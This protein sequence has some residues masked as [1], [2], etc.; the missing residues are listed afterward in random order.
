MH[1]SLEG[2]VAVVT[3]ASSGFGRGIAVAL[4]RSGAK[5]CVVDVTENVAPGNFDERPD[6]AT[7]RLIAEEGGTALYC[8]CDVSDRGQVKAAIA[9][10][11]AQLGG[12]DI[13]VNNAG[14]WRGMKPFHQ[15]PE[16]DFDACFD[17]I[18][19][20]TFHMCQEALQH[21][22][23][24]KSGNILNIV[25]TAGIKVYPLQ[26]GYNS[27][28]HAQ[29]GMTKSLALEYGPYSV[30]V[31]AICPTGM[32]TSMN[33][34]GFESPEIT[35]WVLSK[36]PLGRWG[37]ISDIANAAVFLVSDQANFVHGQIIAVD[38]GELVGEPLKTAVA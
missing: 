29:I 1:I 10:A 21:F 25:S 5:V 11:V 13:L 19:K 31:N 20:G 14:V 38:G 16:A 12:I 28:K 32:K 30:R 37:E 9:Q 24:Q 22:V 27:A 2:K 15:T 4:A 36:R 26:L 17:V 35:N 8:P 18:V 3:G 6:L 34:V 33:R 23:A 7:A